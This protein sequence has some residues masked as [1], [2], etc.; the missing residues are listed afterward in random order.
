MT[1]KLGTIVSIAVL[2]TFLLATTAQADYTTDMVAQWTF[3]DGTLNSSV[4]DSDGD[5]VS[6]MTKALQPFSE[7]GTTDITFAN[8]GVTDAWAT[9]P[10]GD[11]L[12]DVLDTSSGSA[13]EDL[14][15]SGYTVYVR[16]SHGS[17]ETSGAIMYGL[18][19]DP[20]E[21]QPRDT[22]WTDMGQVLSVDDLADNRWR[23]RV[24]T[25]VQNRSRT[26]DGTAPVDT[27]YDTAI[28]GTDSD[29]TVDFGA[30]ANGGSFNGTNDT[31]FDDKPLGALV[32][33]TGDWSVGDAF[34][35][36]VDE[37]RIYNAKLTAEQVGQIEAVAVPEPATLALLAMGGLAMLRRRR[38]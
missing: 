17:V 7:D 26:I 9:I 33:G 38:A 6:D 35:I 14:A 29:G 23:S 24:T 5:G 34:E 13:F 11:A 12:W 3:N 31:S 28:F 30:Y 19:N 27:F 8:D 25:D 20:G 2:G 37:V 4:Y 36:V 10:S 1:R 16:L 21:A 22:D 32:V 18:S 15:A